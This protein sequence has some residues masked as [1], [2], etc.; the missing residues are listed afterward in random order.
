MRSSYKAVLLFVCLIQVGLSRADVGGP[1]R[2]REQRAS[3]ATGAVKVVTGQPGS[4]VFINNVRH[5]VSS[6]EGV[7]EL[8]HVRAGSYPIRIRTVGYTDWKGTLAVSAGG[9]RTLKVNQQATSDQATL[10]YQNGDQ[11]RDAGKNDDAVKEYE[12][13]IR[14]RPAFPE[15]RLGMARSLI[16]QQKF[17]IAEQQIVAAF[18]EP[19]V[20]RAEAQT[21]LANLRRY[22]GLLDESVA[23]YR[24]ALRL[25]AG[26]SP[27]AHIGLAIALEELGQAQES[28]REFRTGITQDMDTEPILY[29]LLGSALEKSGANQQAI[30]AYR[31]YLRLDPE[32]QYASAV[33]SMIEKLKE[34]H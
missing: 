34:E 24:K 5:G 30:E 16:T 26:V 1:F 6:A 15:A 14:L 17:E 4:V 9:S 29:Y 21:L 32:G 28:I 8:S 12:Q 22:Q 18:K 11:L 3:A 23:E 19:G 25:A 2:Q 31:N 27:E 10:H 20:N 7:L 33:E 13:A